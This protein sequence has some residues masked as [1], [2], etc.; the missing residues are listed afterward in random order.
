MKV[1]RGIQLLLPIRAASWKKSLS[2]K[3]ATEKTIW[4]GSEVQLHCVEG[5]K[6]SEKYI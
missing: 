6:V 2:I 4:N 1:V 5:E 3:L